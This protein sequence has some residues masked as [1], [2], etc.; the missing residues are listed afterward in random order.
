MAQAVNNGHFLTFMS[1]YL[2]NFY[3]PKSD[4]CFRLFVYLLGFEH[5]M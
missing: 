1:G 5:T 4:F 2:F 3:L